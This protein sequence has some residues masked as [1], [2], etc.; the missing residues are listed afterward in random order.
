MRYNK[1]ILLLMVRNESAIIER[2]LRAALECVDAVQVFDTGSTDDTVR[3]ATG[4]LE[5]SGKPFR[6]DTGEFVNF[7]KSRTRSF[8]LAQELCTSL[9]YD[10]EMTYALAI[11]ADMVVRPGPAFEEQ[12]LTLPGYAVIQDNGSIRYYNSRFMKCAYPW[13]CLGA[14]HEY[15]SG[16]PTD[17]LPAEVFYIDDRNDGGC[18]SDKFERDVRLLTE[19]IADDPKNDRAHFYLGQSLKDLGRFEEAIVLFRKRI[20]LGGWIE[21]VWYSHYQIGKCFGHLNNEIEMEAWMNR[22]F[23][24]HPKRAEPL[25]HLTRYFREKPRDQFKAYHYYLKGRS[26]PFPKDDVLFIENRVYEG[27]F[28]YE[29]T[30]LSYY[31]CDRNRDDAQKDLLDFINRDLGMHTGNAFDNLV[32]Y[33]LALTGHEYGGL[34][35]RFL[36]RAQDEYEASSVSLVRDGNGRFLMNVRHVNYSIDA[37]GCYHMRSPDGKVKTRNGLVFLNGAYGVVSDAVRMLDEDTFPRFPNNIEGVED[38]RLFR[39]GDGLVWFTGSSKDATPDD[40]IVIVLGRYDADGARIADVRVLRP[41]LPSAC[42]KNWVYVPE[43]HLRHV[44]AKNRFN[45]IFGWRPLRIGA[46][47]EDGTLR[48]HTIHDTPPLFERFRGS[49]NLVEHEGFLYTVVHFVQYSTPRVYLHALIRFRADDTRPLAYTRLFHFRRPAI[50]Y[51]LGLDVRG[52]EAAFFFSQ[53]DCDPS[54]IRIPFSRFRFIDL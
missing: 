35:S 49:S 31:T 16:D 15:W 14:T 28:D 30:I 21:E 42:E 18:K 24:Y 3:I 48:I 27:L 39:H 44:T 8:R 19:E 29:N 45:F 36:F 22:A 53:N 4:V 2:C 41:P 11:D 50:E 52:D 32:H 23:E 38:V 20:A 12:R 46:V 43:R 9:G 51:C 1:L 54:L 5:S 33:T 34:Y 40:D 6:V 10:P 17:R 26:I 37:G 47:G 13:K 7:G 25:Y